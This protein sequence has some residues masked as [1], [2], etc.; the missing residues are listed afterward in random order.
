MAS[1]GLERVLFSASNSP[2]L[3]NYGE[4]GRFASPFACGSCVTSCESPERRACL[5]AFMSR[6]KPGLVLL[7]LFL[8]S[9][10]WRKAF[11]ARLFIL[12]ELRANNSQSTDDILLKFAHV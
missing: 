11:E 9:S 10:L 5:Q 12:S 4:R 2:K 1:R 8:M 6:R 7:L 3:S